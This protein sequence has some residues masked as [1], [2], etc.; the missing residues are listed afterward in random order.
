M[1]TTTPSATKPSLTDRNRDVKPP[2]IDDLHL[3]DDYAADDLL[4]NLGYTAEFSRNRSTLQVA[5]MAFVLASL[6]YGMSTTLYYPLIGGGPVNIIWGWVGVSFII[7][8]V[9]LS[10]GEITSVFPTAGGVY[11]QSFMLSPPRWRRIASWI[12][13]WF[14]LVGNVTIIV[15]V[16]FATTTFLISCINILGDDEDSPLIA[17]DAYQVFLIYVAITFTCASISTF[18]N[19]WLPILDTVAI[20]GTFISLFAIM[21]TIL[22]LAKNG[23]RD[24]KWVFTHFEASSGWPDGWSFCIGLLHAAYTTSATGM[25]TSMCEEVKKPETQV[26]RAM[27]ATVFI[28]LVAGLMILVPVCF[29]L[30]DIQD[31]IALPYAQP[32]PY[33]FKNA[34]GSAGGS[35]ALLAPLLL[36]AIL[37]G[38]GCCTVASRVIWAFARDGAVP[39]ARYWTK[40]SPTLQIPLNA[41]ILST[42]IQ[43]LLGLIYFGSTAAFNA[44]SGV[45]V[46]CLTASYAVPITISFFRGRKQVRQ[47]RFYFGF[48]G[49]ICNV[50]AIGEYLFLGCEFVR[51]LAYLPVSNYQLG[52]F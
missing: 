38:T 50:V 32:M 34:T 9:A 49:A 14:Y 21:I 23:R 31:L 10:L 52:H 40:I 7:A 45:G 46:I 33:I 2:A 47:G 36:L 12:C 17:G 25:I 27:L 39:G 5:F 41:M 37:C 43:V 8:C 35:M 24:A 48:F 44:F 19:R 1:T 4:G 20:F 15:A 51:N 42:V 28:N 6:P 26:P 3:S 22:V 30:P 13:G 16:N 18:G 29:V 11:Y